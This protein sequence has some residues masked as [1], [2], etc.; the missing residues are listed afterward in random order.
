MSIFNKTMLS[1]ITLIIYPI[2]RQ[3]YHNI[4]IIYW[5]IVVGYYKFQIEIDAATNQDFISKLYI[6]HK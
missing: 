6:K 2:Y 5:L 4:I 1:M 3:T